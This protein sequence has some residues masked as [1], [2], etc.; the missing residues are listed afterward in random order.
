M[1]NIKKL[2]KQDWE[3]VA[4][5]VAAV[6]AL[7]LHFFHIT[8]SDILLAIAV[9]LLALSIF[10]ARRYPLSPQVHERLNAILAARRASDTDSEEDQEEV[11][12]LERLLVG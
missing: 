8:E 12:E 11:K 10:F 2:L 3:V 7:I 5:L 9:V 4:V 1:L 6:T